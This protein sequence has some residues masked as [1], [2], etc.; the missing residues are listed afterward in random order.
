[1]NDNSE[2]KYKALESALGYEFKNQILL[3]RALT[4]SSTGADTNY[5]RL[6]FLGD[7]VLGLTVSDVL[8]HKFK[9][10]AEGD[11]ARRLASLAAGDF[12]A[13]LSAEKLDLGSY[14][15][16]SDAERASGGAEN[17]NILADVFEAILGAIYLDSDFVTCKAVIE[18]IFGDAFYTMKDPPQH[19]K[20]ALQEWAQG[21]GLP[22][23]IYKITGQSG[24]DHAPLFDLSL[25]VKGYDEITAQGRSRQQAEKNAAQS[26][27]E[28]VSQKK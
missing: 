9:D 28:Q 22:L 10:E 1:M 21:Q 6:E 25:Q 24:P 12:L 11:L 5:E 16:F 15:D 14:I 20:T 23:P 17:V 7:R 13:K 19:P 18:N 3:E 27:L 4:H 26:F 2:H 8:Y